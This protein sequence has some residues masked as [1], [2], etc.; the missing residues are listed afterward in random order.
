MTN[1]TAILALPDGAMALDAASRIPGA[2]VTNDEEAGVWLTW[3][4]EA[5]SDG[6]GIIALQELRLR[7]EMHAEYAHGGTTPSGADPSLFQATPLIILRG[8]AFVI[9]SEEVYCI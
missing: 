9:H 7:A 3:T 2:F 5:E 8:G 4:A 6:A 1:Y